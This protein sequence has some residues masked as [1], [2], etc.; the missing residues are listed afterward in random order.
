KLF[1]LFTKHRGFS[2]EREW[3]VAY[4]SQR[5]LGGYLKPMLSY[6]IGHRGIEPKLKLKIGPVDGLFPDDLSLNS[7][8][9]RIIMGPTTSGILAINSVKR[10]LDELK[11]SD[12]KDKVHP[13]SI[14]FRK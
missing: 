6:S 3:C 2:E 1:S 10:M 11:K 4:M 13:S 9:N 7:L 5:D 12:L 8:I 14:P